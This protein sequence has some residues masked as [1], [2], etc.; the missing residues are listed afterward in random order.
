VGSETTGVGA[1]TTGVDDNPPAGGTILPTVETIEEDVEDGMDT[2]YGERLGRHN[3]RP[4][5]R[6]NG[7]YLN[8]IRP[9]DHS[10]LHAT[11]EHYVMTQHSVKKGLRL[12]GDA[13]KDAV[14]SEMQQL[15]EMEAIEPKSSDMLTHEEKRA[16]LHYLM[17]L[18]QKRCGRIKGRGC[19]DGRK[20]R[21]YKTKQYASAPTVAIESL[22]LTSVID[23]KERRHVVTTD[24]PGAFLQ[25]EVDELIHVRLEGPLVT[26]L[27]KV[28]PILYE[29]YI[30]NEKGK[31]VLYVKLL[32]ALYG[33]LQAAMLFW[34]DLAGHLVEW[35]FEINPYDCCAANKMIDGKQCTIVWHVNDL[36]ISHVSMEAI[37]GVLDML[38]DRYGKKK[39]LV[40]TRGKVHEYL[41]MTL[42]FSVNGKVRVIM[43]DYIEE[44][45]VKLEE[46]MGGIAATPAAAHLFTVNN[47]PV[48]LD[49]KA[50]ESFHHYT[51]KL[52]FLSRR[53][54]PDILMAVAFLCT[55]VKAPDEDDWKK[56]RRCI[57][58]LRGSLDIIL[59]LE[60]D[61]LHVVK[62]WVDASYAVH[63]D[64]KSHTRATMTLGKGS[65]YSA[66]TRQ[67]LNTKSSTEA[68]LVGVDDLMPQIL[69]TRYFLEAQG[70]DVRENT[71]YQD[72]QSSIL[73][74]NNGRA[75]SSKRTRHINI[76]YFFITDRI[77]SKEA[78]VVYCPTGNMRGD[79]FT[80]PLQGSPYRN[81]R[82][83][84]MNIQQ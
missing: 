41:G 74:E 78:N 82:V 31:P 6:P 52:L 3:L 14:Y 11:L 27:T 46:E 67:K 40:T 68:E 84:I 16:S 33:T 64:M 48:L 49:E 58:Y 20:Q 81:F 70:Y 32:K 34:K 75:S 38:N 36:K 50:S 39:P 61:N 43:Q 62:W 72:N 28:D 25:T 57:Q 35:G 22:S 12:F 63:P 42:D 10:Q 29:K 8:A 73:L 1:E 53:A 21:L 44:M 17:F 65:V 47:E 30:V 19:A 9:Q 77:K 66:S 37:E 55:R 76:R 15:H 2:R 54:R 4:R 23:A 59:T 13:G 83:E 7:K 69:W 60:A 80:K 5:K 26:L 45:C 79:F 51:A 71:I 18:K 24:I 56:F